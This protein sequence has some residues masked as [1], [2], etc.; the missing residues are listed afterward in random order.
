MIRSDQ[1]Q[2]LNKSH[3]AYMPCVDLTIAATKKIWPLVLTQA[4]GAP[5]TRVVITRARQN[6]HFWA[7]ETENKKRAHMQKVGS[8][9]SLLFLFMYTL[10]DSPH[11]YG[12]LLS[13]FQKT[14]WTVDSCDLKKV[15]MTAGPKDAPTEI[16]CSERHTGSSGMTLPEGTGP[17][18]TSLARCFLF[19]MAEKVKRR[20][21]CQGKRSELLVSHPAIARRFE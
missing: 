18:R 9:L 17:R 10:T 5:S 6:L 15:D 21:A 13:N 3:G 14:R 7:N 20:F 4:D 2:N 8:Q 12:S 19:D 11:A 1:A 16:H